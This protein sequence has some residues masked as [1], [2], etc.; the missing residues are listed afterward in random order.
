MEDTRL[1]FYTTSK[2]LY[3][4]YRVQHNFVGSW[5]REEKQENFR[6]VIIEVWLALFI[7]LMQMKKLVP[8]WAKLVSIGLHITTLNIL[9][10]N[11]A[12]CKG[13]QQRKLE[14]KGEKALATVI[15]NKTST[16]EQLLVKANWPSL[17]NRRLQDILILMYN[18]KH[19]MAHSYLCDLFSLSNKKYNSR[20]SDF[21]LPSFRT[22]RFGNIQLGTWDHIYGQ[23]YLRKLGNHHL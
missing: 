19:S 8:E 6:A 14:H 16:Y 20:N 18:V 11:L 5:L 23:N 2:I 13:I 4:T 17:N 22:V 10:E 9:S 3:Q 21:N 7:W 1:S 12:L 15:L